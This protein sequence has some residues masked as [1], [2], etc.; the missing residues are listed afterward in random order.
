MYVIYAQDSGNTQKESDSKYGCKDDL[1]ANGYLQTPKEDDW[2]KCG[3]EVLQDADDTSGQ[4]VCPFVVTVVR[5]GGNPSWRKFIPEGR[6]WTAVE[7]DGEDER[8]HV[9]NDKGYRSPN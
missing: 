5:V 6:C 3:Y 9:G 1:L 4:Q 2:K 7:G 8:N